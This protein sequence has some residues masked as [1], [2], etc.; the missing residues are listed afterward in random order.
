MHRKTSSTSYAKNHLFLLS[1]PRSFTTAKSAAML[2][3]QLHSP[4][5]TLGLPSD[6]LEQAAK[7]SHGPASPENEALKGLQQYQGLSKLRKGRAYLQCCNM[8]N[9]CNA[10]VTVAIPHNGEVTTYSV[11]NLRAIPTD[12]SIQNQPSRFIR[13]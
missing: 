11:W 5:A 4:G 9:I 2:H 8:G 13:V 7:S 1:I 6:L 10:C 12:V 3:F